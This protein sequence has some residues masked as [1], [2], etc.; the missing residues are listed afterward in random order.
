MSGNAKTNNSNH[1]EMLENIL[2]ELGLAISLSDTRL[3]P[4]RQSLEHFFGRQ[5]AVLPKLSTGQQRN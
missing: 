1:A 4:L 5:Q 3:A 2:Q